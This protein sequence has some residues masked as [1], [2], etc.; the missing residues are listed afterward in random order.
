MSFR[1]LLPACLIL[2][3]GCKAC[4]PE[5]DGP[6]P[7]DTTPID[8]TAPVDDTGP[9]DGPT[10]VEV[11]QAPELRI[12]T[13]SGGNRHLADDATLLLEGVASDDIVTV[14]WAI[15]DGDEGEAAGTTS[16]SAELSLEQGLNEIKV[17]GSTDDGTTAT[18]Y[19][20][21]LW[22]P[23][24]SFDGRPELD[25]F[26]YRPGATASFTIGVASDGA[27]SGAEGSIDCAVDGL[28][29]FIV[30]QSGT[31][32][33]HTL[34]EGAL[35]L[36]GATD[37][38][39]LWLNV[40]VDGQHRRSQAAA[41][42][43]R[44]E[45]TAERIDELSDLQLD[46]AAIAGETP[47]DWDAIWAAVR[48]E[49]EAR[50]DIDTVFYTGDG[51]Y[52]LTTDPL[53][54]ALGGLPIYPESQ[55]EPPGP[56]PAAPPP[57]PPPTDGGCG[58]G[59]D[60][61]PKA[62]YLYTTDEDFPYFKNPYPP[63]E[64]VDW[65]AASGCIEDDDVY[66]YG[67]IA[68]HDDIGDDLASMGPGVIFLEGH[69]GNRPAGWMPST[70][71]PPQGIPYWYP[72][73][74]SKGP[75]D[76]QL[77]NLEWCPLNP[78]GTHAQ[79]CKDIY[80][81]YQQRWGELV[82]VYVDPHEPHMGVLRVAGLGGVFDSE[83]PDNS[84]DDS[85]VVLSACNSMSNHSLH[86]VFTDKGAATIIGY[87]SGTIMPFQ[88]ELE[89]GMF[90][91]LL[92]DYPGA[93][94]PAE[95]GST[96]QEAFDLSWDD[97]GYGDDIDWGYAQSDPLAL[98]AAAEKDAKND[99]SWP[100]IEGWPDMRFACCPRLEG[101]LGAG[102]AELIIGGVSGYNGFGGH[103]APAGDV[104]G[105]GTPDLIVGHAA[106]YGTGAAWLYSGAALQGLEGSVSTDS[107]A[108]TVLQGG[109]GDQYGFRVAGIGDTNMDGWHD[110]LV[111]APGSSTTAGAAY[112]YTG[113]ITAAGPSPT[114]TIYG[115]EAGDYAGYSVGAALLPHERSGSADVNGD[116][117]ED[118]L[119]GAYKAT[120]GDPVLNDSG[121]AYLFHG[122]LTGTWT[123]DQAWASFEGQR[124]LGYAGFNVGMLGDVDGDGYAE[125]GINSALYNGG[126]EP[127]SVYV[128]EG[129]IAAGAHALE[130]GSADG[131]MGG[132]RAPSDLLPGSAGDLNGDGYSD[133]FVGN[134][135]DG[136]VYIVHGG[137]PMA[138]PGSLASGADV[139]LVDT[140]SSSAG[141]HVA[142]AGD[143]DCDGFDDLLVGAPYSSVGASYAGAGYLV[144]GPLDGGTYS[145][146]NA[147]SAAY[148][149][150]FGQWMGAAV[151]GVGDISGGGC[152]DIA[153]S[154][155]YDNG[156]Y[157]MLFYPE[158]GL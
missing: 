21:A 97:I 2:L 29:S 136:Q 72:F 113:P 110:L 148:G 140:S 51:V 71:P 59:G 19:L 115:A 48:P 96:I 90:G 143:L 76:L 154:A 16:W 132:N 141:D 107:G 94:F 55:L 128:F 126:A 56:M 130:T 133:V 24:I 83:I 127:A 150:A 67:L 50:G 33:E 37:Q 54:F 120:P 114:A 6:A 25:G 99:P 101:G 46:L 157:V 1:A 158:S 3:A 49:L 92:P 152:S 69:G 116:G 82:S 27:L 93:G 86:S 145:L 108:L 47:D 23:D 35:T 52:W 139:L 13:P 78:D 15:L 18:A 60:G 28:Q 45:P 119:L 88:A 111:G 112:L 41:L 17:E 68:G 89:N 31:Q 151:A 12:T 95:G 87:Y 81:P 155:S 79:A 20:R 8:D 106:A 134:G 98:A 58:A 123:T 5:P 7:D 77:R 91:Y 156:G 74:G 70:W 61:I 80:E 34:F 100:V 129:P 40:E 142:A 10:I 4:D 85:V 84:L 105:D 121:A 63:D 102:N 109:S 53:W 66:L 43:V 62:L 104:D 146:A 32:G 64:L 103:M 39:D 137:S 124:Y 118:I 149:T 26:L 147:D 125:V 117:Y 36:P 11:A 153:I 138:W 144:M 75:A 122:P 42:W 9:T 22:Q 38:C 30:S 135:S 131:N 44:E 73:G 65:A 57:P 14:S